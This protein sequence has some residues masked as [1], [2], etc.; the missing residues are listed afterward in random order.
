MEVSRAGENQF[1][2]KV[3]TEAS[4][5]FNVMPKKKIVQVVRYGMPD[6]EKRKEAG[7][8][9]NDA[10][11]GG[12]SDAE[13]LE[14]AA[15]ECGIPED[16]QKMIPEW[17]KGCETKKKQVHTFYPEEFKLKVVRAFFAYSEEFGVNVGIEKTNEEFG[18]HVDKSM[19]YRW[20]RKLKEKGKIADTHKRRKKSKNATGET[21]VT[22]EVQGQKCVHCGMEV[23]Q[24]IGFAFCPFCGKPL[25]SEKEYAIRMGESLKAVLMQKG[26]AQDMIAIVDTMLSVIYKG[27]DE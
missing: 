5:I 7:T 4:A 23:P 21:K 2:A 20:E 13:A 27:A 12:L 26:F 19:V 1:G 9:Y 25:E 10:V 24:Y 8:A 18:I 22:E 6:M 15:M 11:S 14:Y 3:P 17:A 16:F